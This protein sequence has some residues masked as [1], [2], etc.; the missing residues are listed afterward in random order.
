MVGIHKGVVMVERLRLLAASRTGRVVIIVLACLVL[1]GAFAFASLGERRRRD[2]ISACFDK[3]TGLLRR[4]D[5][6]EECQDGEKK[7]SWNIRGPKGEIGPP[8][9][10]GPQGEVGPIGPQGP[11]GEK[12]TSGP[13][14]PAGAAGPAGPPGSPGVAGVSGAVE[15]TSRVLVPAGSPG[16]AVAKCPGTKKVTGGGFIVDPVVK[17]NESHS[18][19]NLTEWT[20]QVTNP[21]GAD[22]YITAYAICANA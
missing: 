7:I 10:V 17:V 15:V 14:G 5:E 21:A 4:R 11:A 6:G 1:V 19:A 9:E 18:S 8:G 3:D 12:G 2:T 16:S 20:L 22:R 13:A